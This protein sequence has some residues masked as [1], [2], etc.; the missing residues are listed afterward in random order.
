[1]KRP[2]AIKLL[3]MGIS[4]ER[5]H[6]LRKLEFDTFG[7]MYYERRLLMQ[8]MYAFLM[9]FACA[10][11]F[12]TMMYGLKFTWAQEVAYLTSLACS[13][14]LN[15]FVVHP[16]F[17]LMKAL[18]GYYEG[19]NGDEWDV[20]TRQSRLLLANELRW[21]LPAERYFTKGGMSKHDKKK[22]D[23]AFSR[24]KQH[25]KMVKALGIGTA[26]KA[27]GTTDTALSKKEKAK[28]EK[29]LRKL[30]KGGGAWWAAGQIDAEHKQVRE[31]RGIEKHA[32]A[33]A[34]GA[35]AGDK[36][37]LIGSGGVGGRRKFKAAGSVAQLA[38]ATAKGPKKKAG[39]K[40]APGSK[41]AK[42][43]RRKKKKSKRK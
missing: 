22:A 9:A 21:G 31:A 1:M 10:A 19:Y 12:V 41:R 16:W 39:D 29:A 24:N 33:E 5:K 15:F 4:D 40:A 2:E 43:S 28:A 25:A 8:L 14:A 7:M 35:A 38:A 34:G 6:W 37:N 13:L 3:R 27:A 20:C 18:A 36:S 17:V 11:V 23:D 42:S 30:K 26:N 32:E